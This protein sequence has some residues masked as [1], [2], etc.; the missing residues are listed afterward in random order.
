MPKKRK[1]EPGHKPPPKCKAILLCDQIIL[2]QFTGKI[3]VV[4]VFE[5]YVLSQI[6]GFTVKACVFLQ[7]VEGIG[8]C[9]LEV[10]L[11]DVEARTVIGRGINVTVDFS[12]RTIKNNVVIALPSLPIAKAGFY[13]L[14]VLADG[15]E[16][17]RQKFAVRLIQA[18]QPKPKDEEDENDEGKED[19]KE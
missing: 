18:S 16:V 17:D 5:E 2:D 10:R 14:V 8:S 13:D 9:I 11:E 6:P 4:G 19:S 1:K 7:L 12:D 15:Q 3:S